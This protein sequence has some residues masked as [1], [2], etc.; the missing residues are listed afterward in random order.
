METLQSRSLPRMNYDGKQRPQQPEKARVVIIVP[1]VRV[2]R[3]LY[4]EVDE[5]PDDHNRNNPDWDDLTD[6]GFLYH[7]P[8]YRPSK[9]HIPC[10]RYGDDD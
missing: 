3:N 4:C 10:G 2:P 8:E 6:E 1:R 7:H 9:P 5:A